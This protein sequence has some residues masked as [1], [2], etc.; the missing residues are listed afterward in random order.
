MNVSENLENL[1][2]DLDFILNENY[3]IYD[4]KYKMKVIEFCQTKAGEVKN[5]WLRNEEVIEVDQ[6]W[7]PGAKLL[8]IAEAIRIISPPSHKQEEI[9]AFEM[10]Y[11][12][13]MLKIRWLG[14][15][16][17]EVLKH[18]REN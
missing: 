16:T 17:N 12:K 3:I 7:Y 2:N 6:F 8:V 14:K 9:E 18:I 5:I 15:V 1:L 10:W 13:R 4:N 11:Y